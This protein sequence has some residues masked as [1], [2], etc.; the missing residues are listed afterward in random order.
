M[1]WTGCCCCCCTECCC[2]CWTGCCCCW[3]NP[4]CALWFCGGWWWYCWGGGWWYIL[5]LGFPLCWCTYSELLLPL[6]DP[7]TWLMG[8]MSAMEPIFL[9]GGFVTK[10]NTKYLTTKWTTLSKIWIASIGKGLICINNLLPTFLPIFEYLQIYNTPKIYKNGISPFTK[11]NFFVFFFTQIFNICS[12]YCSTI[13]KTICIKNNT[14]N[15][16]LLI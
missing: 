13:V 11:H 10:K 9:T 16:L 8:S 6:S 1:D 7:Y 14:G 3:P 12:Q 5:W 2:W 4:D 15:K